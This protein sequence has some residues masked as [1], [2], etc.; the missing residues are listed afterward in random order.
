MR[1]L[2]G[3]L[4][5][6]HAY[7]SPGLGDRGPSGAT[8]AGLLGADIRRDADGRWRIDRIVPGESSDQR[9]RSPLAVPGTT[10]APGDALLAVNGQP[11]GPDGPGPLLIGT[12]GKRAERRAPWLPAR[13]GHGQ[14]G[15]GRLP[16]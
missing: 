16:P 6:S 11:I 5:T 7:V 14:R 9:A 13:A 12:A 15:L 4:G 2:L 1:E 8:A 3:E 10:V